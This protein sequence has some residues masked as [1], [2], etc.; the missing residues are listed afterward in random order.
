MTSSPEN[1]PAPERVI[2]PCRLIFWGIIICA[3][4][5]SVETFDIFNDFI[6]MLLILWGVVLL[7]RV[8]ISRRY[9][10]RM[11]FLVV[12][13]ILSTIMAFY[14]A[15]VLPLKPAWLPPPGNIVFA[16]FFFCA[17]VSL[18]SM[19]MFFRCMKEYCAVMN[20]ERPLASW[21]FSARMTMY[22][23]LIPFAILALPTYLFLA[24][25]EFHPK[26]PPPIKERYGG[27]LYEHGEPTTFVYTAERDGKVIHSAIV[28]ISPDGVLRYDPPK[29]DPSP[30]D[31]PNI[32]YGV[33]FV[34]TD[35]WFA[36]YNGWYAHSIVWLNILLLLVFVFGALIHFWVS[37][38]RMIG[39]AQAQ[40]NPEQQ[41]EWSGAQ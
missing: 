7:F 1:L 6:G 18:V 15:I 13:A 2:V 16:L 30:D 4:G 34:A 21:R 32:R 17:F 29:F 26:N 37:L 19:L 14:G 28:P 36:L 39:A 35:G 8:P 10:R 41:P 40:Q 3:V 25:L 24:S 20:W 38:S 5:I 33:G 11:S 31:G 27:V 22:G 12:I 23:V 9:Q